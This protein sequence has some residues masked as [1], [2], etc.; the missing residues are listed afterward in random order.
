MALV[1]RAMRDGAVPD[2]L[3]VPVGIAY[4]AVPAALH[5]EGAVRGPA[6]VGA[7][8]KSPPAPPGSGARLRRPVNALLPSP[9]SA[10]LSP[11]ASAPASGQHA[12]P[13]SETSAAPGWTSPTPSS[14]RY[15]SGVPSRIP[16]GDPSWPWRVSCRDVG[17]CANLCGVDRGVWGVLQGM[18]CSPAHLYGGGWGAAGA[19]GLRS[20]APGGQV[21][22]LVP[23][24]GS[25]DR[26]RLSSP[27]VCSQKPLRAE[28]PGEDAG[29]AVAAHQP[30]H[31]VSRGRA[32]GGS[33]SPPASAPGPAFSP[34][35]PRFLQPQ[36]A[37]WRGGRDPGSGPR[38]GH[39]LGGSRGDVG[40]QAGPALPER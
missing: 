20:W 16:L 6:G 30:R 10:A 38:N 1:Y 22:L 13:C 39:R 24:A 26:A 7:A 29:G 23:R 19:M 37:G 17:G 15:G 27:G 32:S 12:G 4:D 28:L 8:P 36:P 21:R 3:L 2:V 31:A 33:A 35:S 9:P 40:D 11:S 34:L 18:G 5:Q 25:S 14:Y